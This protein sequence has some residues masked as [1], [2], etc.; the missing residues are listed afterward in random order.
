MSKDQR[1]AQLLETAAVIVRAEGTDAL[2]LA[3]LAE[4]AGVTKPI[5]YEHFGTRAGLLIALYRY[6]DERQAALNEW[7]KLLSALEEGRP[8]YNVM[9]FKKPVAAS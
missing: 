8:D 1:R 4:Q 6:F 2:T 5:A 7:A 9:V 3:R